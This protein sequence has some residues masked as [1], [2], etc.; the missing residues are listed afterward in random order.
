MVSKGYSSP[1]SYKYKIKT[2]KLQVEMTEGNFHHD[3]RRVKE[4]SWKRF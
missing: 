4:E 1:I 2:A 3:Y